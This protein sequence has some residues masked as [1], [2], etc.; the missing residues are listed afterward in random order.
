MDGDTI[1][2]EIDG[3]PYTIRY[4]GIDT[5]ESTTQHDRYGS[6]ASRR[7]GELV[8]GKTVELEPDVTEIDQY[9]R[10]LRYV[11]ADGAMV[12]EV[13]VRE[14]YALAYTFPPDVKYTDRFTTAQE[15]ARNEGAG[16]WSACVSADESGLPA[17]AQTGGDCDCSHFASHAEAQA[18][19]EM[20]L[21]DDPHQLDGNHDGQACESLP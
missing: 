19:Y 16:L 4:I 12:N 3:E 2:V 5:P 14:G 11:Y 6:E 7:N 10:L 9:G 17:C 1:D 13:L 8:A 20:F 21:P 18:F 15:Q